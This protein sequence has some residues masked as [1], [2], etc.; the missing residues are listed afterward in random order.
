MRNTQTRRHWFHRF[1]SSGWLSVCLTV[2]AAPPVYYVVHFKWGIDWFY[3]AI[4]GA[5]L[6]VLAGHF[7]FWILFMLGL[8]TLRGLR[9]SFFCEICPVCGEQSLALGMLI[10]EP[11]SDPALH[12][13][14]QLAECR[15]CHRHFHRLSDGSYHEQPED[16]EP[17][18]PPN[19]R[20]PSQLP[21]SP[22]IQ[23]SD[24]QRASSSGG[25][26]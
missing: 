9:P 10:S 1:S 22:E 20:P 12:R 19:S 18:A 23:P 3:T 17:G 21:T 2:I 24:S 25:C 16:A 5:V 8:L 4:L 7:L 13:T 15:R 11:T 14:Y 6:S 26:G